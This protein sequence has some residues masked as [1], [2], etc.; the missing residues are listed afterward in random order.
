M[1]TAWPFEMLVSYHNVA[2]CHNPQDMDLN[3]HCRENLT[4]F[5][6]IS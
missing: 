4:S 3:L 1:E 5:V 2:R 6:L